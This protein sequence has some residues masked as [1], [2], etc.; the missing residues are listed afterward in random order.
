MPPRA[1]P[2]PRLPVEAEKST[3]PPRN[4]PDGPSFTRVEEITWEALKTSGRRWPF[5]RPLLVKGAVAHWPAAQ[6]WSFESLADVCAH[7]DTQAPAKFTD[8]LVEQGL[9]AGRPM[10]P[11]APYLRE[12]G[13][14]ARQPLEPEIGL[15]PLPRLDALRLTPLETV[16]TLNWAHMQ[17]F[18]PTTLYLAQWDMLQ[19]FPALRCD[20]RIKALWPDASAFSPRLTWKYI[21][22]GPANTVTGLHND[23][24][25][26]WFCQFQG[27]KEFMLFPPDQSEYLCPARK[28]D[29]GATLSD[30]NVSRLHE[31]PAQL[32]HFEKARGLHARVEAGDALFI[33]KRTWHSVVSLAPSIS[34]GMFGLSPREVVTGGAR[35]TVVDWAHH[36]HLYRWGNCTCHPAASARTVVV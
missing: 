31:Q 21:F 29:W 23:F 27:V 5:E 15:L 18:K 19:K 32:A 28:Y 33:P 26:N 10:L 2:P 35:A 22:M 11:V 8:G 20:L 3:S 14:L 1:C 17:S 6:Q 9:T 16:F 7:A 36:L 4:V 34:L 13:Q 24:P 25:H 30:V 12:L